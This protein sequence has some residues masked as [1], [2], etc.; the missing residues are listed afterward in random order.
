M[1][2]LLFGATGM[3]GQGVLRECLLD[4]GVQR[5]LAV[6][7]SSTEQRDEK[8]RELVLPD[9]ADLGAAEAELT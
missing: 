9:V 4:P 5:V 2:V 6:G 7:R 3:V 8:L 1:N